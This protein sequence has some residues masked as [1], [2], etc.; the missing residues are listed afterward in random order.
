MRKGATMSVASSRVTS[1]AIGQ[2]T[3]AET[4][5]GSKML[6]EVSGLVDMVVNTEQ[7]RWRPCAGS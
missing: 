1:M 5:G 6:S 7:E 4:L 2:E 3:D